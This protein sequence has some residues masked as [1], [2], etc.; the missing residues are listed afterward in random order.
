M[1]RRAQRPPRQ[2]VV[3]GQDS[4]CKWPRGTHILVLEGVLAGLDGSKQSSL[5][6]LAQQLPK[7]TCTHQSPQPCEPAVLVPAGTLSSVSPAYVENSELGGPQ[8]RA[9]LEGRHPPSIQGR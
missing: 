9:D 5:E 1:Q 2:A 4:H 8:A 6:V 3:K 7:E